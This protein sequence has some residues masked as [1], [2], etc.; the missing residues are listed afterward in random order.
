MSKDV[1]MNG[2][3][4]QRTLSREDVR[5][6][7]YR[8]NIGLVL[9]VSPREKIIVENELKRRVMHDREHIKKSG[10][11]HSRYS[12]FDDSCSSNMADALE[13][14][15]ILAH[16]PRWLPFP[17]TPAELLAVLGKSNRLVKKNYYPKTR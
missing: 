4:V 7:G 2:G 16:D 10:L 8:D 13:L 17:V 6:Q 14:I 15:G 1:Y 9:W 5:G 12:V 11:G 3:V